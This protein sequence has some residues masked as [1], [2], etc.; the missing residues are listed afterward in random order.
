LRKAEGRRFGS[1]Q[2]QHGSFSAG[3]TF[4]RRRNANRLERAG[5]DRQRSRLAAVRP[6]M[7]SPGL[8]LPTDFG[9]V[10]FR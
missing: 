4:V 9:R 7:T 6:G 10:A 1:N 5:R 2:S 8:L 3:A